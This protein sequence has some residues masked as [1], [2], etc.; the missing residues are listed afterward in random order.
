MGLQSGVIG[1]EVRG[2][3]IGR[4]AEGTCDHAQGT[5]GT[6]PCQIWQRSMAVL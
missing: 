4:G 6:T 5:V 1:T 3:G 2:G